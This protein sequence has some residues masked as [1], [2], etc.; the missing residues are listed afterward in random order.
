MSADRGRSSAEVREVMLPLLRGPHGSASSSACSMAVK[1]R[2][3]RESSGTRTTLMVP[4]PATTSPAR[5]LMAELPPES[6]SANPEG[7]RLARLAMKL[8]REKMPLWCRAVLLRALSSA[9]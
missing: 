5:G 1:E 8:G 2:W 4:M 9:S 3:C 6:R 7:V